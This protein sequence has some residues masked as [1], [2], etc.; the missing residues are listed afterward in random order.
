MNVKNALKNKL[1]NVADKTTEAWIT[2][3]ISV[4][5]EL[6]SLI[7]PLTEEEYRLL[8]E[9][10]LREGC[11]ERLILWKNS[12]DVYYLVD[13]HNRYSICQKHTG[14]VSFKVEVKEFADM[15]T[16]KDWMISNQLGKRNVTEETKSYLRGLQYK[17]EKQ[18]YGGNRKSGG[19]NDHL[20]WSQEVEALSTSE[21]LA[22]QHKVSAKTIRRDEQYANAIDAIAGEDKD[23]KWKILNKEIQIP[24]KV[25]EKVIKENPEALPTFGKI[26]QETQDFEEALKQIFPDE[27]VANDQKDDLQTLLNALK[28]GIKNKDKKGVQ[29]LLKQLA[30][31]VKSW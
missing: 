12:D 23:L 25:L 29:L 5:P 27:A 2:Q 24:K 6:Q 31:K 19:H 8:E 13:G 7:P 22:E 1:G 18:G 21:R 11:R 9:S 3:H 28:K 26:V 17:R 4:L 30:D 20:I 10:I 14:K 16:V 15:E